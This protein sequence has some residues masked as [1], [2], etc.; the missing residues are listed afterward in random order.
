MDFEGEVFSSGSYCV[1]PKKDNH[2]PDE[3]IK[4]IN[5]LTGF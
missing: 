3:M 4:F 2:N 1:I 5:K